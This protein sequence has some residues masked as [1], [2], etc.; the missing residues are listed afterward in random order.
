MRRILTVILSTSLLAAC[1][2]GAGYQQN[3]KTYQGA[4]AGAAL[5]AALGSMESSEYA[6]G[7]AALGALAGGAIG[8][9]MDRQ[10]SAMR[11]QMQGTGVE[12]RRQGN[13]I[14]L[15]M[16]NSITFGFDSSAVRPEF[17]GTV[18]NMASILNQYPQTKIDVIGYTDS[19]GSD[20]YNQN[21]SEQR[22]QSVANKLRDYGVASNRLMVLGRGE[23]MPVASND[24]DAGR[25]QNRRVE[26][27]ISP[28]QN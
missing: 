20:A 9:Y 11:Q 14:M 27:K 1:Q 22:A 10:E 28:I 23:S 16:P 21:L 12:V 6:A 7:G 5:G 19:K 24:T 25:A 8:Q 26:I 3:Q 15:N 18:N 17:N 2:Q 13:D 4:G